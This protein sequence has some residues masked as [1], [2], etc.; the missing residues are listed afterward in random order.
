MQ[1]SKGAVEEFW[2]N[3]YPCPLEELARLDGW[4][5]PS[6]PEVSGNVW[7]VLSVFGP[8]PKGEAVDSAIHWVA[9]TRASNDVHFSLRKL[10]MLDIVGNGNGVVVG[11]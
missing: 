10:D 11:K 6:A 2:R 5:I 9:F 7:N 3:A 1:V 8:S 4:F